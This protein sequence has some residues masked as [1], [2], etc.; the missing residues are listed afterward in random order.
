MEVLDKSN[1]FNSIV[2]AIVVCTDST[3]DKLGTNRIQIYIPAYQSQHAEDYTRYMNSNN[4]AEA[5][6]KDY[7]PWA[8]TLVSDL[9]EGTRVYCSNINNESDQYIIIGTDVNNPLNQALDPSVLTFLASNASGLLDLAMPII[10]SN[11]VGLNINAWPDNISDAQ[12]GKITPYDKGCKCNNKSSC[13]HSGGW[14]I[15][16]IQWHHCRAFDCLYQIAKGNGN[17]K[18]EW[19]RK[20]FDLYNDLEKS[21]SSG[22]DTNYRTKY[23][24]SFHPTV[25]TELYNSIQKMLC[26][27]TAKEIQRKYACEDTATSIE[28]ASKANVTNPAI[29][30]FLVDIMNQYGQGISKTISAAASYSNGS[31][32]TLEQLAEFRKWCSSNISSYNSYVSRRNKTYAYIESLEKAG[33]FAVTH[34]DISTSANSVGTL[35]WPTPTCTRITS[36]YGPRKHPKTGK[37]SFHTGVD[38]AKNGGA[39]GEPIYAAHS[40][41]VSTK[42]YGGKSYGTLTMISNGNMTTYYAHQSS[43]ANGIRNGVTVEKGQLIGYVGSTG[44]S[45]GPHLHF[46]VRINGQTQDPQQYIKWKG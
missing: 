24:A 15:G 39:N 23:Q 6:E 1:Y 28:I 36:P 11:E 5:S 45:T 21:V 46:E 32:S 44:N 31:G 29:M 8:T 16:L 12:Y 10:I 22:S 25:G 18:N 41:T 38:L 20:D 7:F 34:S 17:W 43:R 30:I 37:N 14:S 42:D 3:I 40:G 9:K 26:T 19:S 35:N 4:K 13:G 33:K 27:D 2:S